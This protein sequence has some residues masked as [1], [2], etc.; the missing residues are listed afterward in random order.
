MANV[1]ETKVMKYHEVPVI[2]RKLIIDMPCDIIVNFC[3]VL[4]GYM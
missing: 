1:V 2:F 3:K 4:Y